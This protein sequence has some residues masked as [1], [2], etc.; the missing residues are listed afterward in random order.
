MSM[1]KA[2]HMHIRAFETQML[3]CGP[4]AQLP[5]FNEDFW[6]FLSDC[7]G[8]AYKTSLSLNRAY[9]QL[10]MKPQ[11]TVF[12][13][14]S[15]KYKV[16]LYTYQGIFLFDVCCVFITLLRYPQFSSVSPNCTSK[17]TGK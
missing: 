1:L 3:Q 15:P 6:S 4:A 5:L 16:L 8:Y 10:A 7:L 17:L 12:V 11:L 9:L 14:L 2:I 13:G